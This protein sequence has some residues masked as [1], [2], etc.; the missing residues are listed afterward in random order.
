MRLIVFLNF[1]TNNTTSESIQYLPLYRLKGDSIRCDTEGCLNLDCRVGH[2]YMFYLNKGANKT[3]V[4]FEY[5]N[6]N[7][8]Q[9]GLT[10]SK[11]PKLKIGSQSMTV[12]M[13]VK[14]MTCDDIDVIQN[15]HCELSITTDK[16]IKRY[17]LNSWRELRG[18]YTEEPAKGNS[19]FFTSLG[20]DGKEQGKGIY[21]VDCMEENYPQHHRDAIIGLDGFAEFGSSKASKRI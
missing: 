21:C 3:G 17:L 14:L 20:S 18:F 13:L 8:N 2:Y 4:V 9:V 6:A 15:N 5:R 10:I 7:V 11:I 1:R 19:K 16:T 12:T